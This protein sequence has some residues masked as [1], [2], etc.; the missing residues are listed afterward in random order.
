[1]RSSAEDALQLLAANPASLFIKIMEHGSMSV[2]VYKP[3]HTDNQTPHLQDELYV[4]ISGAGEFINAGVRV[5]FSSGD[6]LFVPAGVEHRFENFSDDFA[7]W[8][9]FYGPEGGER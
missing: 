4:I 1:M 6:V 2:E 8:V 9:I 3:R 7:T 5:P